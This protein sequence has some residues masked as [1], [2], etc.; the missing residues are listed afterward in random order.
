MEEKEP[1]DKQSVFDLTPGQE[2]AR[3]QPVTDQVK[4]DIFA[5]GLPLVYQD[6]RCPTDDYFIHEYEDGRIY[7]MLLK[8]GTRE[9][10]L[11]KD[12]TNA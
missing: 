4:A 11:V 5:H 2:A 3:L 12:L 7:L 8:D 10:E 1:Q 9:F 6:E